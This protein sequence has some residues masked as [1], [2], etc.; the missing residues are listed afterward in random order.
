MLQH[1]SS[2][3][4]APQVIPQTCSSLQEITLTVIETVSR[5][6]VLVKPVNSRNE[7]LEILK[8]HGPGHDA[9]I[10]TPTYSELILSLGPGFQA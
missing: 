2:V 10:R 5:R 1:L 6:A 3:A 4:A 8:Q 7:A 9:H